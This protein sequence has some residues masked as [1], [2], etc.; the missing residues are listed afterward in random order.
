M[1]KNCQIVLKAHK[2]RYASC[3]VLYKICFRKI[4]SGSIVFTEEK[5]NLEVVNEKPQKATRN[6]SLRKTN[7][8]QGK[9][10]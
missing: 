2:H 9:I 7:N 1:N 6:R 3:S 8:L 5:S 10:C 4:F